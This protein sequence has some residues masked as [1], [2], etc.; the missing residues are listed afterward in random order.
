MAIEA[1]RAHAAPGS[2]GITAVLLQK[3]GEGATSLI[4]G[5]IAKVWRK[6]AAWK[7][8][9]MMA[10]YKG[11]GHRLDL[12]SYRGISSVNVEGKPMSCCSTAFKRTWKGGSMVPNMTSAPAGA[13]RTAS[14]ACVGWW[15]WPGH[16][17]P[18]SMPPSWTQGL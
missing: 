16:T 1:L 3:G 5:A 15:S 8:V 17:L 13:R 10:F 12:N 6:G 11:K 14:S 18:P 7:D 9:G 4:H 2:T